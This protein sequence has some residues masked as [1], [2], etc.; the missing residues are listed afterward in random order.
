MS[1]VS[2]YVYMARRRRIGKWE[3]PGHEYIMRIPGTSMNTCESVYVD[4]E[5]RE[6]SKL[7][8]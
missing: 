8:V 4:V 1:N 2:M 5:E 3:V 7:E 6:N